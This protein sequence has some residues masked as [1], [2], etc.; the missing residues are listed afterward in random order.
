MIPDWELR[1][2]PWLE[3]GAKRVIVQVEDIGGSSANL[4]E[5]AARYGAQAM[6]SIA[7]E[8]PLEILAAHCGRFRAFQVMGVPLGKSGQSFDRRAEERLRAVRAAC[9]DAILQLDGGVTPEVARLAKGAGADSVVS[10]S[11]IWSAA[12]PKAAYESLSAIE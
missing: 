7:L 8:T 1:L 4:A 10:S 6:L 9:P 3:A 11:Y 5:V 12:N 2:V